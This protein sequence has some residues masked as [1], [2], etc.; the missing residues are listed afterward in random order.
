MITVSYSVLDDLVPAFI[1]HVE[2]EKNKLETPREILRRKLFSIV[3]DLLRNNRNKD[4]SDFYSYQCKHNPN[5]LYFG[6][7]T[8]EVDI[9][10]NGKYE[11]NTVND[12]VGDLLTDGYYVWNRYNKYYVIAFAIDYKKF[13]VY[14][15]DC[16]KKI[17]VWR[18]NSE[19]DPIVHQIVDDDYN[20][21][22]VIPMMKAIHCRKIC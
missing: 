17:I 16:D 22:P 11:D 5:G 4:P 1:Y 2:I 19:K 6:N 20:E 8:P 21:N 10:G 14:S 7:S 12:I 3:R 9:Y 15:K 13:E 18:E